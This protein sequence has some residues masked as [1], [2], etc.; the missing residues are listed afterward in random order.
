MSQGAYHY[1]HDHHRP[2]GDA[3]HGSHNNYN[4]NMRQLDSGH[5]EHQRSWEDRPN[6]YQSGQAY[7]YEQGYRHPLENTRYGSQND[8][9]YAQ[10]D[11]QN[12]YN[13]TREHWHEHDDSSDSVEGWNLLAC[14]TNNV[15]TGSVQI[16]EI[17]ERSFG[18]GTANKRKKE[19]TTTTNV[20]TSSLPI[21]LSRT[22]RSYDRSV[23]FGLRLVKVNPL[24]ILDMNGILCTRV[25]KREVTL[26][27]GESFR[28]FV[29]N[30]AN[31]PII[32]RTDLRRLLTFLDS[33]FTLAVWTS[34]QQRTAEELVQLLFPPEVNDRLLF[35]WGQNRC[36]AV[37]TNK[38][39][40]DKGKK[41]LF[42][43]NIIK[44]WD[45]YPLWNSHNSL[46]MDDSPEKIPEELRNNSI[47][48]PPLLGLESTADSTNE[49]E[50]MKF[51]EKLS[52]HFDRKYDSSK[53]DA[54][55]STVK[56]K[57]SL[58]AFLE[59]HGKSHMGWRSCA[60]N[61]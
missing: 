17:P 32:P 53:Y 49:D 13:N 8:Y 14:A 55:E 56:E 23:F 2:M 58:Y 11:W 44:V 35:V 60:R 18:G 43:K 51:F 16:V 36:N 47:H 9:Q 33:H 20:F 31:T 30:V 15:H 52:K 50:Q 19:S 38:T 25:R 61:Y 39:Y 54:M 41:F 42:M 40:S 1:E 12:N 5:Y 4:S 26:E 34:A 45:S 10:H 6:G 7:H 37:H 24:L 28:P 22:E 48:P 59:K 3:G 27:E 21:P 46:L 29:G 57:N